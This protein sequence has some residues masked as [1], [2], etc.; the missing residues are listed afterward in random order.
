MLEKSGQEL[1]QDTNKNERLNL[2]KDNKRNRMGVLVAA[3]NLRA[4]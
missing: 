2:S 4:E 3:N 1:S